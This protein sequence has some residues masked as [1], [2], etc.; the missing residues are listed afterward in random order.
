MCITHTHT[1]GSMVWCDVMLDHHGEIICRAPSC[2]LIYGY[3]W[4]QQL[5]GT[6]AFTLQMN[7]E[8]K[9]NSCILEV[10]MSDLMFYFL[11]TLC[12]QNVPL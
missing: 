8:T 9:S 3:L 7:Q 5:T 11:I 12:P 10:D 4:L 2:D 6:L 1:Q